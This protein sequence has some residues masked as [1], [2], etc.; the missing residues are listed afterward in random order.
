[1]YLARLLRERYNVEAVADGS[2]LPGG[3]TRAPPGFDPQRCHDAEPGWLRPGARS[4]GGC[5]RCKTIPIIL[6][7][8]RAGEESRVEGL[9][10]GADDY[11]IKP[12]S[13]RELLAR[14]AAHLEM[15]R[16]RR[17]AAEQIRQGEERFRLLVETVK[18]YAIFMLDAEGR[19][20]S[21]NAGA[22]RMKGYRP[23]EILGRSVAVFYPPEDVALGL[24][25]T[26][27]D[28]AARAGHH[29]VEGW[30]VRQDGSRFLADVVTT[31][32]YAPDGTIRGYSKVVRDITER[33]R[34]EAA[35]EELR[36]DLEVHQIELQ[37]QNEELRA[38]QEE[39]ATARDRYSDLY[40]FAPVGYLTLDAEGRLL[41]ANFTFAGLLGGIERAEL[42][43]QPLTSF[44]A[45]ESQDDFHFFWQRLQRSAAL[46]TV[47]LRLHKAD[48]TTF[49]ARLDAMLAPQTPSGAPRE[50]REYRLT[51]SN[52]TDRKLAEE[53]LRES[54]ERFRL[55]VETVKDYAIFM[56][57]TEGHVLSW[58]AG[59]ERMKGYTSEEIIGYSIAI[60]Y[61]PEDIA[62]G[63]HTLELTEAARTGHHEVEGWRVRKDGSR[64]LADVVTT[65]LYAPDGEVI[66]YS[67]VIRDI[68]ERKQAEEALREQ[69][70]LL[71][72]A[73]DAII[74]RGT[75]D[76]VTFWSQGAEETYGWKREEAMGRVTHDLL[77]TRF[78][79][80]LVEISAEAAAQG[81]WEGELTHIRKDGL[82]VV[83]ASRWAVQRDEAGRQ[84]GVM[85][86]NRDITE[87]KRA[88][89]A[90]R[91]SEQRWATTLASIGDAVIA[92]DVAGRITFMNAVAEA[93]TGWTLGEAWQ[94]P[95][96]DVFH[97][98]N[99]E[100]RLSVANPVARVLESGMIVGLANH[101]LLVRQDGTEVPIDDS[102]APIRDGDGHTMGVVLVF[103]DITARKL[104]E[105]EREHLLAEVRQRS[106]VLSGINR[107]FQEALGAS[108]EDELGMR[109]LTVA[110]EVTGSKFGFIGE[111][112]EDGL[113]DD[114]AISDPGW[115]QCRVAIP[116]AGHRALLKGF[117][118]HGIYGRV[119]KDG[120]GFFTN[121]PASHPDRIGVPPGH[122]ALTS[123]LG[124]PLLKG[125][126]VIGM[127][128]VGNRPDGYRQQEL[129]AMEA[130]ASAIAEALARKRAEME[131]QRLLAEV[132]RRLVELDT[133]FN[134]I[135]DPMIAYNTDGTVIKA[136]P[137]IVKTLGRDPAG[138]SV[139]EVARQLAMRH[140]DGTLM[141]EMEI[142]ATRALR[143]ESVKGERLL[144]TDV[145][146]HE[147]ILQ[148]T[149]SPLIQDGTPW[150]VV[151][152]WHDITG[153]ERAFAEAERRAAELN[154]TF[155]AVVDPLISF[156]ARGAIILANPAMRRLMGSDPID[157]D[158]R[159]Y[160][161]TVKM[162]FP[163]GRALQA[164]EI[165]AH[166]ALQGERVA[167][168]RLL[169]TGADE[170]E[171]V[172]EVSATP[173]HTNGENRGA[174]AIWHDITERER[175]LAEVQR[176][177]A[178]LDATINGIADSLVIFNQE[179]EIV[180]MNDAA[181]ELTGF[182]E[183]ECGES[184]AQRLALRPATTPDGKPFLPEQLPAYRALRG[185]RVQGVVMVMECPPAGR[186]VWLS[187]S[188]GPILTSDHQ[189]LGAVANYADITPLHNLQEQQKAMLQLVSHDLR[190]PL[191]VIKGHAQVIEA[192]VEEKGFDGIL[193][194]SMTAIDRGVNRMDMM[195]QDLVDVT[196]WEGGQLELKRE[197]VELP[198]YLEN[199]L[200]RVSMAM[201]TSRIQVDMPADLPPVCADYARLERILINLLSN[202]LKYSDPGTPVRLRASGS[203]MGRWWSAISDQGRGITPEEI[204]HLFERFYRAAGARKAE[205]IGL[206]LYIT[207]ILVEA[208]GGRV[209]VES[210]VGKGSTFSVSLP[211]A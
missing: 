89:L 169:V 79:K 73:H 111:V 149:A 204:P 123:F 152:I 171:R 28:E 81:W 174:V 16:V 188:A 66:G 159:A 4:A 118:V 37:A 44:I 156:D 121:D 42:L 183:D 17:Q 48:G 59:A 80:P 78:P 55:L 184:I 203:R 110:E 27:L 97:I 11:L 109:C 189:L 209:W 158:Y 150:G 51:V 164:D 130:M 175:L 1:M 74:V 200:Q 58:N 132:Q 139:A 61:T 134:A 115:E 82:E 43:Q 64:F 50:T 3:G 93:L 19:V 168:E 148:I 47:E 75:E 7:S 144:V 101:T 85:E 177:A 162:C 13:A 96:Q 196:R 23:E 147:M 15:A 173:V 201:E 53:A 10:Q 6:L 151:S 194:Q 114:I 145:D 167:G 211:V 54:E 153:R 67:K 179:G 138:M 92:T 29:E 190:A 170:Q 91:E 71:D 94:K 9:Q 103:R 163:D 172:I 99:E 205:G 41:Q 22:E 84:I 120:K 185:E 25:N 26:E 117:K 34:A 191:T 30:R 165:P 102:G 180:R 100:S 141:H 143:G 32:L 116:T 206:G 146:G 56:L 57:D 126:Q 113:M 199:L 161:V 24:H 136:N 198:G 207:R 5:P 133:I 181:R 18:D 77:Q 197:T 86:I 105:A 122:P 2:R 195:I 127:V 72:L 52:I 193:Q 33:K 68:T 39:L 142:P 65:A 140:P 95:V 98:I 76:K 90:L 128:A 21:W 104:A 125:K 46:E 131:R 182:A 106:T 107:I 63:L 45:R 60:F 69:A 129:E 157:L 31:A 108:T 119:L 49:W 137:A 187:A 135:E 192:M 88:E 112:N 87:G 40:D 38:I 12:F 154:A 210:E 70:A 124:V 8:A 176:R 178:E 36:H 62:L 202:A 208:H 186:A 166:R 35:Q 155:D 14:V 160:A 20:V 83:V